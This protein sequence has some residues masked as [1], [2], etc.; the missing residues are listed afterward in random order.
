MQSFRA[1]VVALAAALA[2]CSPTPPVTD[3][4]DAAADVVDVDVAVDQGPPDGP[5]MSPLFGRCRDDADCPE[6]GTCLLNTQG[7]P[8]GFCSRVCTSSS[9]CDPG[10]Q[11]VAGICTLVGSR[12]MC[13]RECLNGFDCGREGYTCVDVTSSISVC[14]PSCSPDGCGAGARCNVWTSRCEPLTAPDPP[15]GRANGEPCT[16]AGAMSECRSQLC[17]RATDQSGAYSG[18]N[19]GLCVSACTI[20]LGYSSG[21]FWNGEEFP[22]SNCPTGSVCF[23]NGSYSERDQGLCLQGCRSD[24]D[25]RASE[26]YFC[27][28]TF[29]RGMT[30]SHT[31]ANG[32]CLPVDCIND[33][34]HPCPAG[35]TCETRRRTVGGQTQTYGV[36]RPAPP[37]PDA[38][39]EPA[40][41]AG[42]PDAAIPDAPIEDAASVDAGL[43]VALD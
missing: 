3:A 41:E 39:P 26:G 35:Y 20:P 11:G 40:V 28:R 22:Q 16:A 15:P 32:V 29:P 24:S 18:W 34:M 33:R 14:Q 10:I 38:G 8:G 27:R 5:L 23:P 1:L 31:Y 43:D 19:N 4:G 6:G 12:R 9:E 25:C 7:Y 17:I 2:A 21:N 42:V 30:G 36:C 13:M 37:M